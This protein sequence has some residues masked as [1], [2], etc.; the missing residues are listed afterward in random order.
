MI[1]ARYLNAQ[2]Y[3]LMNVHFENITSE[4]IKSAFL[5]VVQRYDTLHDH[6]INLK[7][8]RIKSSTMQAQPVL[9]WNSL[10][11]IK[12]YKVKLALHVRDSDTLLVEDM[13][14]NVLIGWFAHEL[15]HLV[16][17]APLSTWQMIIY[18]IRYLTS[19]KFKRKAE[20]KADYIAIDH[21]FDQE[22]VA[23]KKY[24]FEND[25]MDQRYKDKI[26]KYYMSIDEVLVCA[27]EKMIARP[28]TGL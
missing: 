26:S 12:S 9:N 19:G 3:P 4:K 22:I 2:S 25:L 6:K 10:K 24:I 14:R 20:Y 8:L 5:E 18:G 16:D 7:Q 17:Y 1:Q 27:E 13:P 28:T 23:A 15:G 21:G 11:G